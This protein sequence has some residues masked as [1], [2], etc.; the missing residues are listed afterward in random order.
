M[1]L[2]AV[3]KRIMAACERS[4]RNPHRVKLVVVSK[5]HDCSE[6]EDK[7]LRQGHYILGENRIQEWR[8]K[9]LAFEQEKQVQ[10]KQAIEWHMIGNLQSNKVKYCKPFHLIHS[11]N[12]ERLADALEAH[13]AKHQHCFNCLIEVNAAAETSKQG[14]RLED[15]KALLSYVSAL[16]YVR[17][18]GLMTMA[19]WVEDPE[20]VRLVFRQTKALADDLGL[21]EV[22][23]GMSNDFEIAIEEGSSI[24][25]IGSAVFV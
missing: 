14:I 8:D 12:S 13:G 21:K 16:D 1:S 23:M 6:I 4:G 7:V 9:V 17:V 5:Q 18:L 19:P 10:E 15:A 25:R 11:L 2:A 24:V 22:S 20:K 3:Q